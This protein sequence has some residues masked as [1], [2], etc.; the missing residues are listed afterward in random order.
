MLLRVMRNLSKL[1]RDAADHTFWRFEL[2]RAADALRVEDRED[3]EAAWQSISDVLDSLVVLAFDYRHNAA[4][5]GPVLKGW[6]D[7]QRAQSRAY[8]D[9]RAHVVEIGGTPQWLTLAVLWSLLEKVDD[10]YSKYELDLQGREA[11]GLI[12]P[13]KLGIDEAAYAREIASHLRKALAKVRHL[14]KCVPPS[15]TE[16]DAYRT[17]LT[18]VSQHFEQMG[19]MEEAWTEAAA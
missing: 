6:A 14:Q 3:I 8:T 11:L 17:I 10:I 5:F 16:L 13:P 15:R 2:E 12:D 9:P 7:D 4:G 18:A 1:V 19:G